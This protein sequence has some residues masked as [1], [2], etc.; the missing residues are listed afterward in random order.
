MKEASIDETIRL[1]RLELGKTQEIL[2]AD[3]YD[4][5]TLSRIENGKQAPSRERANKLFG[6]LGLPVDRYYAVLTA[7]E[8]EAEDLRMNTGRCI[9]R[10]QKELGAE[11]RQARADALEYLDKLEAITEADDNAGRQYLLAMRAILGREDGPYSFETKLGMLLQAVRLTVP[12][13]DL[14]ALDNRLYSID[15]VEIIGQIAGTY[16]DAGQHEKAAGIFNQLLTYL[17]EHYQNVTKPSRCLSPAIL[18]YARE[19]CLTSRYEEALKTAEWGQ[20][21]CL[22]YGYYRPLPGLLAVMAECRYAMGEYELSRTL[23][24][25]ACHLFKE[26][27]NA[28]GFAC[29]E[30]EARKLLGSEFSSQGV[31]V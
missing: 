5:A 30:A 1:K 31:C 18:H 19:L 29:V 3:L 20:R 2:C 25:Q 17:Q 10:F 13:F 26:T 8:A 9:A 28:H 23:Y 6:R 12:R 21:T 7:S 4:P 22:D 14:E 11:K 15:E 16:S 24:R 27:G